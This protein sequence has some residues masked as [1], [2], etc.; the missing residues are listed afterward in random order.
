M[1]HTALKLTPADEVLFLVACVCYDVR[2]YVHLS[3]ALQERSYRRDTFT[4]NRQWLWIRLCSGLNSPDG[5]T[6]QC[7]MEKS[8][9]TNT[10]CQYLV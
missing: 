6:L 8:A 7:G 9:M 1:R 5:S 4:I 2:N 10:P 3:A